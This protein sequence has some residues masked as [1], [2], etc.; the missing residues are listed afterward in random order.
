MTFLQTGF[1]GKNDW[2]MYGLMIVAM[3]FGSFIGQLPI[4][5]VAAAK[6]DGD[7]E[8]FAKSG[9]N[10]FADL[11][12][13]LNLYLFLMLLGF[14]V[15]FFLFVV[16]LKGMQKK[17]LRWVI[18]SREKIDW[19][20]VFFGVLVWGVIVMIT[21]SV[22][23]F[24]TPENYVW[25][26]QPIR[27]L[28]L[29]VVA[30][31][32]IPIQTTTEELWFRGYYMQ[33]F[34]ISATKKSFGFIL[35]YSIVCLSVHTYIAYKYDLNILINLSLFMGYSIVL[36]MLH[37]SNAL[38]GLLK[39]KFAD[40]LCKIVK[41]NSTP[42]ILT[43]VIFGLLHLSNPEVDKLGYVMVTFYIASGLFFGIVTLL[44]EGAEI[45]IGMHAVNNVIAALFITADWTVFKTDALYVDMSE[46]TINFEMFLPI[47]VLYPLAILIFSKK[48]GWS[49]WK[50]KL[51]G[52]IVEPV[53]HE[54]VDELG[55]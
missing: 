46:P 30:L 50:E 55:A 25:N 48:Y 11:G 35:I 5:V 49:R 38:S 47:V 16:L 15:A 7:M 27:F 28:I 42:L 24:L 2:W 23:L 39:T 9:E 31:L 43:S 36:M 51:F 20:R 40:S 54:I 45:A 13:D 37:Y 17:K 34:A 3:V 22:G 18:T 10:G 52:E 6:V 4:T 29:C 41:R 12:I 14:V 44:D 1:K 21:L 53:E 33:S 32:F 26:F 8:K 19:K